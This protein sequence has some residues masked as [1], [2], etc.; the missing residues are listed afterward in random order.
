MKRDREAVAATL[1]LFAVAALGI[2]LE[3]AVVREHGGWVL[4]VAGVAGAAWCVRA[5]AEA[6]DRVGKGAGVVLAALAVWQLVPMPA[7][8]RRLIAPGQAAWL[9]RVGAGGGDLDAWLATLSAYDVDA[10]LGVAQAWTHDP[11]AGARAAAWHSSA[12]AP[13]EAGWTLA[14]ALACAPRGT[15]SAPCWRSRSR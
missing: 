11:L 5:G 12:V 2:A 3:G 9:D 4:A 15:A 1:L 13:G 8:L 14:I 10:A 7:S 6:P